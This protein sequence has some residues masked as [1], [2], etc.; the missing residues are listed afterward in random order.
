MAC[1]RDRGEGERVGQS[2]GYK[3][4]DYNIIAKR[5]GP[6][7]TIGTNYFNAMSTYCTL[8]H[9]YWAKLQKVINLQIVEE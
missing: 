8:P 3:M 7:F 1:F 4:Y 5:L 2:N 9:Y 6:F